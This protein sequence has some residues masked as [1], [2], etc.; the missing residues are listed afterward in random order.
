MTSH[1]SV[2]P[3]SRRFLRTYRAAAL[4]VLAACAAGAPLG[5]Q[6]AAPSVSEVLPGDA[7]IRG[8]LLRPGTSSYAW[9]AV[10]GGEE[11]PMA[12]LTDELRVE[13]VDGE[14]RVQRVVSVRRGPGGLVDSTSTG[15]AGLAPRTHV[16][17]QPS[18]VLRMRFDGAAAA[19][20]IRL[21]AGTEV[22]LDSTYARPFFDS[23]NWDLVVR[24]LPLAAGERFRISVYDPDNGGQVWYGAEVQ[25]LESAGADAGAWRVRAELG[26]ASATLWIDAET[27]AVR[28]MEIQAGPDM[29][30]RQVPIPAA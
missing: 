1:P 5:A 15:R 10:R 22:A 21:T 20:T 16:S 13:E 3:S 19:G 18:R 9:I 2:R 24:A 23:G 17:H 26:R 25:A 29:V 12:T 11:R 8:E 27:R 14:Q 28:R 30:I 6:A 4:A 7:R